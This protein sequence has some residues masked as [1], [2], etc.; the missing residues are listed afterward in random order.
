MRTLAEVGAKLLGGAL[1]RSAPLGGGDLSSI[2]RIELEDGRLAVVKDGPAPP[3]EAAMLRAIAAAG[4]PAPEVLAVDE[5]V[6][7]LELLSGTSG[8]GGDGRGGA[9]AELGAALAR[10]HAAG[11]ERYGWDQDYAFGALPIANAWSDDWPAFWAERRLLVHLGQLAPDLGRRLEALAADLP[12]RLP[13]HPPAA[14]L[15][16]D[17]WGGNVVVSGQRI[18]GLVDPACYYG[19]AEVDLAMLELFDRPDARFREAYGPGET[20]RGERSAIYRLWPALVHLRLFGAGYRPLVER[21]LDE[22]G[23]A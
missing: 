5:R 12:H 10:L 7:V 19:H 8:L 6:L 20:G 18:A 17:L 4:A 23:A 15:H 9:W 1:R 22:A 13:R 16:G 11:G 21:L 3:A 2:L 14:L